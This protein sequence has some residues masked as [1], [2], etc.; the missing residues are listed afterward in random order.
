MRCGQ[1]HLLPGAYSHA[2]DRRE[3]L[4]GSE[5]LAPPCWEVQR[6]GTHW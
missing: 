2:V 5:L 6:W 1:A 3:L 4:V